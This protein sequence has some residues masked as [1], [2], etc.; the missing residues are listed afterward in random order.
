MSIEAWVPTS[1]ETLALT[2]P[3]DAVIRDG[4]TAFV[5]RASAGED[6]AP[7]AQRTPVKVLFEWGDSVAVESTGLA[8]GD[9]V[10]VE[11]N[12]RLVPGAPL[13]LAASGR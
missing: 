13:I 2:A 8:A 7:S 10:V 12:E 3:R 1:S 4:R 9:R 5:Y 6:G 11:G